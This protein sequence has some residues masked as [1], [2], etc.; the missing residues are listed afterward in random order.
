MIVR[1]NST[2][3]TKQMENLIQYSVGFLDGINKGKT[4][5]LDNLG[6][7]IIL[8]LYQYIDL[9]A[10]SNPKALHHVYEWSRVG[11]PEAR[12]Y[13][14]TSTISNLGLSINSSFS[15]SKTMS[16]NMSTPFY[17]KARVMENGISVTISPK[18]S[19]VLKFNVDGEDVFTANPVT[20]NNPGGTEVAGS[21]ENV[22]D[23][24]MQKYFKQS[25][26]SASGLYS[27]IQKPVLYKTNVKAGVKGGRA[28]GVNTGYKW[29]ANAKIGVK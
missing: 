4:I 13:N 28:V 1:T 25:F 6:K 8:G 27:Y 24:F 17:D 19:S 20:V 15:Q 10:R 12:L 16:E 5:F 2:N 9:E 11:S 23:N 18:K 14:L 22:V 3:F 26:L 21:F 7:G 29:I